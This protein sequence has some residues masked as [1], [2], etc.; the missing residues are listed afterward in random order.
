MLPQPL[1]EAAIGSVPG[2]GTLRHGLFL[3]GLVRWLRPEVCVEIGSF[4]GHTAGRIGRALQENGS[5][6]LYCIDD[7]SLG[8]GPALFYNLGTMGVGDVVEVRAGRS[9][10]EGI[11]PD[12]IDFAFIDGDHSYEGCKADILRASERGAHCIAFHDIADWWGPNQVWE[13]ELESISGSA[14]SLFGVPFDGGLGVLMRLPVLGSVKHNQT[15]YPTG[16]IN[17]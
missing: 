4:H 5:G 6:K 7:F 16:A 8:A 12:P 11:W 3:Y 9:D 15:D 17:A 2:A 1:F 10:E 13:E 14:W